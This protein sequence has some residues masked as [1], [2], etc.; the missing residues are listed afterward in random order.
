MQQRRRRARQR[1][2]SS[3]RCASWRAR[4]QGLLLRG[5]ALRVTLWQ[6]RAMCSCGWQCMR[7]PAPGTES[8]SGWQRGL[9]PRSHGT[10]RGGRHQGVQRRQYMLGTRCWA[11]SSAT[12]V[13]SGA[14][15]GS[16]RHRS[17][18]GA[19][20]RTA[21][22]CTGRMSTSSCT[23]WWWALG[24]DGFVPVP[25]ACCSALGV[26]GRTVP[27]A[28]RWPGFTPSSVTCSSSTRRMQRVYRDT[29]GS[30]ARSRPCV[31][32]TGTWSSWTW[33]SCCGRTWLPSSR[34]QL[35]RACTT[36]TA[37]A[38]SLHMANPSPQT[39]AGGV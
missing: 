36:V 24:S 21:R 2:G 27:R 31:L 30:S 17:G 32:P 3:G 8:C 28:Q 6:W 23:P 11:S 37:R 26:G 4:G 22:C 33:T 38:A 12:S 7:R 18:R 1:W 16:R 15:L 19:S 34:Y 29:A 5:Q 25:S 39:R 10:P 20:G 13:D 35:P 9:W 14:L